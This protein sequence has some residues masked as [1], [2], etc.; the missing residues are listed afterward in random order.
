MRVYAK[1]DDIYIFYMMHHMIRV[2]EFQEGRGTRYGA[3]VN[4]V[5]RYGAR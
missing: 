5:M 1:D 2:T 4:Y 3:G